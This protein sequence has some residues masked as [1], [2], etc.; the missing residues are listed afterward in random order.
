VLPDEGNRFQFPKKFLNKLSL[1]TD[2]TT[3]VRSP[4]E[5][6]DFSSSLCVQTVSGA[7]PAS[8]PMG[9]E[10]PFPGGKSRPGRDADHSPHLMS[11]SRMSRSYTSSTPCCLNGGSGAAF[12]IELREF[13][14]PRMFLSFYFL[15]FKWGTQNKIRI[16]KWTVTIF[17]I[18]GILN[19]ISDLTDFQ[20]LEFLF[21]KSLYRKEVESYGFEGGNVGY[22]M[23]SES[24]PS[25]IP[26]LLSS[27][28][29]PNPLPSLL[30]SSV[31]AGDSVRDMAEVIDLR[32]PIH[33]RGSADNLDS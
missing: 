33:H 9:T 2:W 16:Y 5:A 3:G 29:P 15:K 28:Q 24:A 7:Q 19:R 14:I 8:Y 25:I 20:L 21:L 26:P 32:G 12:L 6:K 18:T 23:I 17:E 1:T 4:G 10:G 30:F 11:M 27:H 13:I 31:P 22:I